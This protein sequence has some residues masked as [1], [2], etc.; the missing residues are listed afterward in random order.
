LKR[1]AIV[2][3]HGLYANYG[4]W[5]QLVNNLAEKKSNNIEYLIFNSRDTPISKKYIP[6]VFVHRCFLKASGFEGLFF[7]F[8][9]LLYSY[10]RVDTILLLGVQGLPIVPLLLMF[11]K[12]NIISNTGGIEWERTKFGYFSKL[13]LRFCFRLSLKYSDQIIIDN[14]FFKKYIPNNPE[15]TSKLQIIPYGGIID[16]TLQSVTKY[17][18]EYP[19][20]DKEYFLSVSRSIEDN[21]V[22]EL[23][24]SFTNS[25]KIVVIVSNLSSSAYGRD[26]LKK[27]STF[28][29]IFLIDG[30]YNKPILDLV[31]RKSL[32]Y[33]HTHTTCG[34]A[35]SL[36]EMV[37]AKKPILSIDRPQNRYTL[38]NEGLYFESFIQLQTLLGST[39]NFDSYIISKITR[40]KYSWQKV[41]PSYEKLF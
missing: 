27:Y 13:Y 5:D 11:R 31:R 28:S 40:S 37:I 8:Y 35:P 36:V 4:G 3:S 20:L 16:I 17:K 2:G 1:I 38:N 7:D 39:S 41:V 24:D 9:S 25:V 21:M 18:N 26:I 14:K 19:F 22:K 12:N 33:I 23:C 32:A 15:Y 34:T 10:F 29:N 30:L 6:N